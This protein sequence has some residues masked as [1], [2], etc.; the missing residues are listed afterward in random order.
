MSRLAAEITEDRSTL[1][2][3]MGRLPLSDLEETEILR[4]GVEGKAAA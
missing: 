1:I 4:L 3:I 2:K